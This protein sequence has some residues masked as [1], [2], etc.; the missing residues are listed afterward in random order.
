[1]QREAQ[2][3]AQ[4]PKAPPSPGSSEL[5]AGRAE[6]DELQA[7]VGEARTANAALRAALE[8]ELGNVAK[9]L[10]PPAEIVAA[11]PSVR[12]VTEETEARKVLAEVTRLLGVVEDMRSQRAKLIDQLRQD[13]L[14][15]DIT[16]LLIAGS[17]AAAATGMEQSDAEQAAVYA[18]QLR[19]HD[20]VVGFLRQNLAAQE[21][22][23]QKLEE[24]Y[25]QF[26]PVKR[27]LEEAERQ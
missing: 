14:Q 27:R 22:V 11:L 20:R 4:F 8:R 9:L 16:Q 18:E 19:K 1:M 26:A 5:T 13:L 17:G 21:N 2:F 7:S 23:A 15:D 10:R 3:R 12:G 24:V 25:V 6:L